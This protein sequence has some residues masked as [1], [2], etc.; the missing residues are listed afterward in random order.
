MR[1][2]AAFSSR[3]LTGAAPEG[4]ARL[5]GGGGPAGLDAHVGRLGRRPLG[6]W[7][8]IS[9]VQRSGLRGRGGAAFPMAVKLAAVAGRRQPVM[10]ANGTEGEPLSGKDK[11]LLVNAPHLV[12]DGA[13]LAAETIGA[14]EAIV[15]VDRSQAAAAASA[16]LR[17]ALAERDDAG[18]IDIRVVAA[19][20]R[21]VAGEETALVHWLNGGD[22][23]PTLVPPRPFERGVRGRPTDV[24]NV[25]TLAHLGLIAR[26]GADW[27][28]R[29]G[30]TG[31]PGTRLV[32]IGGGVSRPGV[33]E[34]ACGL[35]LMDALGAAGMLGPIPPVLVGGYFGTWLDPVQVQMARL[36]VDSMQALGASPG[37]GVIWALPE[38]ACGLAESARVARWYADQSAGQCGP[39]SNGLPAVARALQAV[40]AGPQGAGPATSLERWTQMVSGRGAC[41]HPDGAAR[42]VTSALRVF[43]EEANL[44]LQRGP[45]PGSHHPGVLPIPK[46]D[47]WR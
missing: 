41:R 30:T 3:P 45:C 42:F 25:E 15:C 37:S 20:S 7:K 17:A 2:E 39:C 9:E 33:Y 1:S 24:Q 22:A 5:L 32:T 44:H 40:V 10:V 29:I 6:S 4:V 35:P 18:P 28:R 27:F 12:L 14:T 23:K 36:D 16:A 46:G 43:A 31:D 19:P 26:F 38:G 13:L 11:T 21:F 47:G 8:L 34:V